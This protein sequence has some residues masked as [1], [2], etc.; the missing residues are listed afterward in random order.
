VSLDTLK[1][2]TVK[3]RIFSTKLSTDCHDITEILLKVAF[4]TITLTL[5]NYHFDVKVVHL[6][7]LS[8]HCY[9]CL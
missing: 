2:P 6:M 9:Y 7:Y 8:R 3:I 4:N 5:M 1:C